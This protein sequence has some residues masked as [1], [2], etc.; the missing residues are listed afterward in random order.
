MPAE[1]GWIEVAAGGRA[2]GVEALGVG[3]L[4]L[5]NRVRDVHRVARPTRGAPRAAP[6]A[7]SHTRPGA[8]SRSP[9]GEPATRTWPRATALEVAEGAG[10]APGTCGARAPR[11]RPGSGIVRPMGETAMPT[12]CGG[13]PHGADPLG[14]GG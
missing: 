2:L 3:A 1:I 9:Q 10:F 8:G 12:R 6:G 14:R 13:L 4:G 7:V 5:E 11:R